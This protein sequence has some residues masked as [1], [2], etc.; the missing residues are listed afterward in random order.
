[1]ENEVYLRQTFPE[2]SDAE[3]AVKLEWADQYGDFKWWLSDDYKLRAYCQ[4]QCGAGLYKF[5]EFHGDLEKFL[6]REVWTHEIVFDRASI[7]RQCRDVW[8]GKVD[9]EDAEYRNYMEARAMHVLEEFAKATG[10]PV[11]YI[12]PDMSPE[13]AAHAVEDAIR[14]ME[15]DEKTH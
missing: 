12:T 7:I 10:K 8:E 14:K 13:D 15:H 11:I 2:C 4:V 3:I 9:I 5:T 1:M 6:G